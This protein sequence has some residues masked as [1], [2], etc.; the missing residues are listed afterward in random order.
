MA[1]KT[2]TI[3]DFFPQKHVS[4]SISFIAVSS[5]GT[6]DIEGDIEILQKLP[7]SVRMHCMVGTCVSPQLQTLF[8]QISDN[9]YACT[10]AILCN[11]HGVLSKS[12]ATYYQDCLTRLHVSEGL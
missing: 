3:S 7:E 11:L 10:E 5:T 12:P 4:S 9:D 2:S 6:Y 8:L 1:S